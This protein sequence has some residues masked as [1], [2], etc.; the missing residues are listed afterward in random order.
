MRDAWLPRLWRL[1]TDEGGPTTAEYALM[2]AL[3]LGTILL[4][5]AGLGQA[6]H[7]SLENSTTTIERASGR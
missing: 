3:L 1:A 6:A 7:D 4:A 5:V 2:L